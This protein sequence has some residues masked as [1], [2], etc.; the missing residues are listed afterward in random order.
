M[1]KIHFRPLRSYLPA[2][3][4]SATLTIIFA[5][6]AVA[7]AVGAFIGVRKLVASWTVTS[8]P[9]APVTESNA[10]A[11]ATVDPSTSLQAAGKPAAKPWDGTSRVTLLLM[12][13]D[14]R[15]WEAGETPRTD[16]MILLTLDPVGK[17]AGMLSIPRDL[18]VNIPGFNYAKINTAYF[19]GES[20][21]LPGGGPALAM[22]TVEEVIGVPIDYYAQIDFNAFVSFIDHI[23]GV[24][25]DIPEEI[26]IDPIGQWNTITL[27]AGR[28]TLNGK[29]ALAY[30]R[31]RHTEGGDF[32]RAARQQ[33]VIMAVRDRILEF[34]MLPTLISN[35]PL[36][37]QDLSSGVHTN[38]TLDQILQLAQIVFD[39]P[40]DNIHSGIIGSKQI[41]F[42][43]SPDGLDILKP[44]PDQIRVLRDEIF[45]TGGP[46]APKALGT[47]DAAE[48]MKQEGAR[49]SVQ[50]GSSTAGLAETTSTYLKGLGFNVTETANASQLT[51]Q[52]IIIDYTGKPYAMS[53]LKTTLNVADTAVRSQYDPN[54]TVDVVVILGTDWATTN[55]MPAQ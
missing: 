53:F 35:A 48:L 10:N 36:L 29:D 8:L 19:L 11:S 9:G 1:A 42:A 12:G 27:P 47:N 45:A 40:R 28:I 34:N 44:I 14:Y 25:L 46:I 38:L 7:A 15:D 55:T 30:A 13:L 52:T 23:K 41:T 17:T 54:A 26:T 33:Q 2:D 32:D 49:I 22:K 51:S 18:W 4:R 6:L 31:A 20:Q 24:K 43:K 39:I 3:R 21:K 37:Y 5:V 50:N 16:S